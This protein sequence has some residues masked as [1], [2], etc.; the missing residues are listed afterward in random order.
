MV[1]ILHTYIYA[2]IVWNS[3][4]RKGTFLVSSLLLDQALQP[5]V[6]PWPP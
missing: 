4:M 6:G 2:R 5:F 1:P 3:F